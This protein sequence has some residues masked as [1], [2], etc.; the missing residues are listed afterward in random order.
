MGYSSVRSIEG[1]RSVRRTTRQTRRRKPRRATRTTTEI[2]QTVPRTPRQERKKT[3]ALTTA[4]TTGRTPS[5]PYRRSSKAERQRR[6][7]TRALV[8]FLRGEDVASERA[9]RKTRK[10]LERGEGYVTKP[11]DSFGDAVRRTVEGGLVGVID[12]DASAAAR[13]AIYGSED[14]SAGDVVLMA[15]PLPIGK[16]A[17]G[18]SR[19]VKAA[20]GGEKAAGPA[21]RKVRR[22]TPKQKAAPPAI[23]TKLSRRGK[24]RLTKGKGKTV[25]RIPRSKREAQATWRA[26]KPA[27]L[28]K[29]GR[30]VKRRGRATGLQTVAAVSPADR[31]SVV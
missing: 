15:A 11:T 19:I 7:N 30:K 22:A 4:T 27:V 14:P 5:A 17:K 10:A 2:S 6:A 18:A 8:R 3:R 25:R 31:K 23:E 24:A 1:G 26:K 13:K 29:T 28:T 12:E 16:I 20:K 21:M 9:E